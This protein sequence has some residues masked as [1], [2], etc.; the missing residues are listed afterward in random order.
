MTM[1]QFDLPEATA[2]AA[3]EAGLLTPAAR[4]Q[5]ISEAIRRQAGRRLLGVAKRIH[6]AGIEEMSMDEI[7][8]EV[9]AVRAERR[10]REAAR[11][12]DDAGRT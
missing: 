4:E 3:G 10:A 6:E 8:E 11:R 2:K 1:I 9:Q 7:N 12:G 5:L